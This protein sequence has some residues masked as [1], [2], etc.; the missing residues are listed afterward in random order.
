MLKS[1]GGLYEGGLC[2]AVLRPTLIEGVD[3]ANPAVREEIC[4]PVFT[5][6][7][8]GDEEEGLALAAHE[9]YGLAAGLHTTDIARALRD[10]RHLRRHRVDQPLV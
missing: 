6:Q 7:T 1:F 5:V 3:A 8:F 10:A 4:G 9:R 2:G